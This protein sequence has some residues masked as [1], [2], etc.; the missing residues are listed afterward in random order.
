MSDGSL[1]DWVVTGG[2][3]GL[4]CFSIAT[5]KY[6]VGIKDYTEKKIGRNYDRMDEI[7]DEL[8]DSYTRKDVCAILHTQVTQALIEIKSDLKL[9]LRKNG[10]NKHG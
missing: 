4:V 10:L 8:E 9:L 7:K 5:F 1:I 3:L 2:M 6:V